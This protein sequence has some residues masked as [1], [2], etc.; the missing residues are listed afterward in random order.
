M[1]DALRE[2]LNTGCIRPAAA[3]AIKLLLLTGARLNEILTAKWEW[4]SWDIRILALPDIKT[5]GKPVYLSEAVLVIMQ[6]QL[7]DVSSNNA[8][9][10]GALSVPEYIFPG[11]TAGKHMINLRKPW[12]RVCEHAD[13][14]GVRLHDLRHTAASIAVGQGASRPVMRFIFVTI[15]NRGRSVDIQHPIFSQKTKLFRRSVEITAHS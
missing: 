5:A 13:I 14:E 12:T 9:Q 7:E 15:S 6:S 1:G 4:V 2:L 11:R 10:S 3:N 8:N